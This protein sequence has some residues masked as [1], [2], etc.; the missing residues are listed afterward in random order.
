MEQGPA[1]RPALPTV[2][3][4]AAG[5]AAVSLA[6]VAVPWLR[7][8][9][10]APSLRVALETGGSLLAVATVVLLAAP[11]RVA[12]A[13]RSSVADRGLVVLAAT[14]LDG[15]RHDRRRRLVPE[16]A[17]ATRSAANLAGTRDAGDRRVRAGAQAASTPLDGAARRGALGSG[18]LDRS[19]IA[20]ARSHAG[21]AQRRSSQTASR[22]RRCA[23][24]RR[25][26]PR[27]ARE[28]PPGAAAALGRR[29]GRARRLREARL[30]ALP[31]A[32][33]RQRPPR[34]RPAR[35]RLGRA[36]RRRARARCAPACASA[37]RPR[38]TASAA[39]WPASCTT[40]SPRSS[41][42][43]A[44]APAAWPRRPDGVEI[45]DAAD[46][47]L[48]DSRR[49]IEALVP[50][51]H[52][53]LAVALERLGARLA[54]ECGVEVQ[55]NVRDRRRDRRRR[56]R[57]AHPDHLRGRPQR[58]PPRRRAARARR[59]R[60]L[61]AGACAIIDDGCGFRDGANSGLG[62]RR[63]RPD[64]DARARRAGRRRSSASNPSAARVPSSRWCCHRPGARSRRR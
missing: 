31:A 3:F 19:R 29:R 10:E 39:G 24:H 32:R 18:P 2:S 46:R 14:A 27:P 47:A 6:V 44:A 63:L 53:P 54:T 26:R 60:G 58:R 17:R 57:R 40:A 11:M 42:S 43:S 28:P 5:A 49:A 23:R 35:R 12:L 50:P 61:A 36:V 33:R 37:P 22:D 45:V 48:E 16:N 64:R 52:E 56:P 21:P 9:F 15:R 55:V 38:S 62:R 20:V 30:R 8:S 34:R 4:A 1:R 51:A 41:P 59:S 13:R 25:R 7:M